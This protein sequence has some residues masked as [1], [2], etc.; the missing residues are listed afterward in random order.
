MAPTMY[1]I[2]ERDQ[3]KELTDLPQSSVGAPCPV[4]VASEHE[5]VVAYFVEVAD[6]DWDGTSVRVVTGDAEEAAA[7]VEF[8]RPLAHFFGPPNDEAFSGHPLAGRGL[9]PYGAFEI[10][11]SS[12][13]RSL[14]RMNR[15]HR[16]HRP[17]HFASYRHFVLAFHDSTFECIAKGYSPQRGT[18][19]L[20][21]LARG[22]RTK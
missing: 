19:P 14:E 3:V 16:Q 7:R 4:I 9:H 11:G 6:P 18:G 17:E 12:W 8:V 13:V 5:L 22:P 15:V 2:D 1:A 10:I 21:Q 20:D